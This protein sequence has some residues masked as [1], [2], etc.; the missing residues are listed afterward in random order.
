MDTR[1]SNGYRQQLQRHESRAICSGT[2]TCEYAFFGPSSTRGHAANL[3]RALD[4]QRHLVDSSESDLELG[5]RIEQKLVCSVD[6]G[7]RWV[8][9]RN[10]AYQVR[11]RSFLYAWTA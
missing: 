4:P 1:G 10:G 5:K 2:S 3:C 9:L 11:W 6:F 7:D 8:V